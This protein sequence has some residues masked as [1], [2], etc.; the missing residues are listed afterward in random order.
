MD[1]TTLAASLTIIGNAL[2][3][4]QQLSWLANGYFM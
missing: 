2:Q 4:G 1:Q 3:A